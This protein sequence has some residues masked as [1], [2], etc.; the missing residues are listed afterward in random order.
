M[1]KDY[2]SKMDRK[3]AERIY[4]ERFGNPADFTFVFVGDFNEKKLVDLC[5]YY[6]GNLKTNENREDK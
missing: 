3:I 6:L 2:V 5:A 4:F 1:T